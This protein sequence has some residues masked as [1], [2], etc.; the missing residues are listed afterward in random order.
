MKIYV[1]ICICMNRSKNTLKDVCKVLNSPV[2]Y[3]GLEYKFD[4]KESNGNMLNIVFLK[5]RAGKNVLGV[6]QLENQ[7]YLFLKRLNP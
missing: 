3:L 2:E 7:K 1:F 6:E 4:M 5:K